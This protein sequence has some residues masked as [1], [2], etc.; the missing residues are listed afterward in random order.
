MKFLPAVVALVLL[1][2][3]TAVAVNVD[4][5]GTDADSFKLTKATFSPDPPQ[6]GKK[7]CVTLKG[8]LKKDITGGNIA[9]TV[10]NDLF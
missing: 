6:A 3:S 2:S 5:C 4:N 10:S 8:T 9:V 1:A 7:A